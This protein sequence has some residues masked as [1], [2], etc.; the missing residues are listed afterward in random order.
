MPRKSDEQR[1]LEEENAKLKAKLKDSKESVSE[2]NKRIRGE[3]RWDEFL[4]RAQNMRDESN[5]KLT[6]AQAQARLRPHYP[7]LEGIQPTVAVDVSPVCLE[8]DDE[9][10]EGTFFE[11][12]DWAAKALGQTAAGAQVKAATAPGPRAWGLFTWGTKNKKDFFALY[13]R[14]S[15]RV[16]TLQAEDQLGARR[17]KYAIEEID[18]MLEELRT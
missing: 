9:A 11:A 7:P 4:G 12:L 14:E 17:T 15:T 8:W 6:L 2:F 18:A 10:E 13:N 1:K 3:G 16:S 5:G